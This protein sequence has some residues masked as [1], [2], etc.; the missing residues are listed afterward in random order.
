MRE[1]KRCACGFSFY[2]RD[3]RQRFCSPG[4]S[5]RKLRRN[6]PGLRRPPL[7]DLPERECENP[8]CQRSYK[9]SVEH[10]RFCS[11]R[12][13][14]LVRGR[15]PG[16]YGGTHKRLRGVWARKV[17]AG[18]VLCARCGKLIVP[19]TRWDLGH[20][21]GGGPF[22]YSGP[23]HAKCNR[24]ASFFQRKQPDGFDDGGRRTSVDLG[25]EARREW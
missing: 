4:C 22:D 24:G 14:L 13:R 8:T 10:Q 5:A 6:P 23:E 16:R 7:L 2:P 1:L 21:D 19:G 15:S 3:G 9:P 12:C 20:R 18:G 11:D 25:G 17:A